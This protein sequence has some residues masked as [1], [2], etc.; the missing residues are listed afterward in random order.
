[1][2]YLQMNCFYKGIAGWHNVLSYGQRATFI[3]V[4]YRI[5]NLVFDNCKASPD[6]WGFETFNVKM[7][8]LT[9]VQCRSVWYWMVRQSEGWLTKLCRCNHH[10]IYHNISGWY[11]LPIVKTTVDD[12]ECLG[13]RRVD[14]CIH[15]VGAS[16]NLNS[17]VCTR[18]M[19]LSRLCTR[20][21][22]LRLWL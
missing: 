10:N 4:V 16:Q 5:Q 19:H 14:K 22:C 3:Y 11:S 20:L 12:I 17:D 7:H 2:G 15:F 9:W 6:F 18:K 1:M 21:G 8:K 13:S